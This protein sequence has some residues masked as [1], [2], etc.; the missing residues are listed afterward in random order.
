[1]LLPS[2]LSLALTRSFTRR[3]SALVSFSFLTPSA[4]IAYSIL[5]DRIQNMHYS[6]SVDQKNL[7]SVSL[8]LQPCPR[9]S[10][11]PR[12]VQTLVNRATSQ[13]LDFLSIESTIPNIPSRYSCKSDLYQRN[14][15]QINLSSTSTSRAHSSP[16]PSSFLNSPCPPSPQPLTPPTTLSHPHGV[17]PLSPHPPPLPLLPHLLFNLRSRSSSS[18]SRNRRRRIV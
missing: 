5:W 9:A 7:L 1:M 11:R 8:A 18:I 16:S 15:P 13:K 6:T 2:Y 10:E 12:R 4:R 14:L 3:C 17:P